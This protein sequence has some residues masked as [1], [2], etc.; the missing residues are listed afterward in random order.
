MQNKAVRIA[1]WIL[2]IAA[3]IGMIDACFLILE[4]LAALRYPGELTPCSPSSLV[5]CTKTVQGA[6]AHYV[7]GVP[8]PLFGALWYSAFTL[9]GLS[10]IL[11]TRFTRSARKAV[12]VVLVA[13][14]LFSYRLYLASVLELRGVCPFC[15]AST[16]ASTLIALCVVVD[17]RFAADGPLV[18]GWL[19]WCF[20]LFQVFSVLAF[21]VGLPV[22]IGVY[23]PLLLTPWEAVLHWSFPVMAALVVVLAAGHLWA[24][25]TLWRAR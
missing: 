8:N 17:D 1:G 9:Y 4:Y 7:P 25:R 3:A 11:G 5:S 2:F 6:W 19:L 21:V 18:R 22:F 14:L 12:G 20:W 10:I 23:L 13:G 24:F 15:L 16:V